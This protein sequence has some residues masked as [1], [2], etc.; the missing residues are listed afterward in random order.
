MKNRDRFFNDSKQLEYENGY[1]QFLNNQLD[2][3]EN[4][5]SYEELLDSKKETKDVKI[6]K[7][8]KKITPEWTNKR[9]YE[10]YKFLVNLQK[11]FVGNLEV[12]STPENEKLITTINKDLMSAIDSMIKV[13]RSTK[14]LVENNDIEE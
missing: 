6:Q 1:L 10:I 9:I 14:K 2:E 8:P 3:D 4:D 13:V 11:E 12:E 7:V 5:L